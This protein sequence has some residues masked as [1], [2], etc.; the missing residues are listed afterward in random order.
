MR[1]TGGRKSLLLLLIVIYSMLQLHFPLTRD[2]PD[3]SVDTERDD[4][5][6][7]RRCGGGCYTPVSYTHLTLPTN[8]EV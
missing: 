2:F 3:D 5:V 8:R 7:R 1:Q 6:R 4:P